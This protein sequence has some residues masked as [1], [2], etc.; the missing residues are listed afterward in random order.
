MFDVISNKSIRQYF[1]QCFSLLLVNDLKLS[2]VDCKKTDKLN[3]T[4]VAKEFVGGNQA[5]L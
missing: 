3:M 1:C 4:E 5:R 2:H